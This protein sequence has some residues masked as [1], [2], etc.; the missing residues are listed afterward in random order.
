M[1]RMKEI[2]TDLQNKYGENL[3]DAPIG[4]CVE[5]YLRKKEQELE[6]SVCCES[7]LNQS[8]VQNGPNYKDIGICSGCGENV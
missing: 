3:E 5:N 6:Y 7:D 8:V 2:Y 1:G 4:F